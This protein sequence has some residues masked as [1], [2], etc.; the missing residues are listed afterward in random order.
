MLKK[1]IL[2]RIVIASL[3]FTMCLGFVGCSKESKEESK[4]KKLIKIG[5]TEI[6]QVSYNAMK[7]DYES[8]GYKTEF[9]MFDS[10]PVVLE[11]CNNNEIDIALGQHKK[12]VESFNKN[13]KG[14][15]EVVKPYGYYTGIG[16][17]SE[18]HKKI[19]DIKDNSS[20]AIMNDAMNMDIGLKVLQ[21]AGLIKLSKKSE[22]SYT[23]A[24]IVENPKNL[25][26]IDMDQAQTVRSLQDMDAALVFF[27]HMHNA[28][29]DS[30][31]YLIRDKESINCPM[32]PIAK[33]ENSSEKWATD[34]ASCLRIPKVQNEIEKSFPGVF[35]FYKDDSQVKN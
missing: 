30:K 17:Y 20:I 19:E 21:D 7:E 25:K 14:N 31:S 4:E 18:K 10:N 29:K 22:G 6:S 8:K 11:A 32:G 23:I 5:G 1:S 15:L 3:A 2:K 35:T 33:K 16:L 9:V 34:F 26:I 12:F 24:D 27:T 13:K 28:G